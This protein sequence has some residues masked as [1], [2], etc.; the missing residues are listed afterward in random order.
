VLG[1][2]AVLLV[3]TEVALRLMLVPVEE[4]WPH[5]VDLVYRAPSPDAV[6]GDSHIFR[7]FNTQETFTNLGGGG[8]TVPSLE[9]V[10]HEYYRHRDPGRVILAASPQLFTRMRE[11][12]GTQQHD[13]YFTQNFGL[14]FHVYVFEPG[15]AR[16]V[17]WLLDPGALLERIR[18]SRER[19]VPGNPTDAFLQRELLLRTPADDE[20]Y[21]QRVVR[22]N[23]PLADLSASE[24][25]ASY[26]RLLDFLMLR[27]ASVCLVRTPV[28]ETFEELTKDDPVYVEA[29]A[30]LRE[31]ARERGIPYVDYRELGVRFRKQLFIDPDHLT[32]KG[33]SLFSVR[34]IAA[35]FGRSRSATRGGAADQFGQ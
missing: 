15:I 6:L 29:H 4:G 2:I 20:A 34:A 18:D 30:T 22:R 19:K 32:A 31:I 33:A 11:S 9:I 3:A 17:S 8:S 35:C 25:F 7:G 5:R 1:G 27:G 24:S 21:T 28:I 14:P 13:D 10:A 23:R 12:E 26:L 16:S